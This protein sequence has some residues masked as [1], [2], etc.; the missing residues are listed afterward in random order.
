MKIYFLLLIEVIFSFIS[1]TN[2]EDLINQVYIS[3]EDQTNYNLNQIYI[4]KLNS[5]HFSC[6][7]NKK[8]L[9]LDKFNDNY[10]DCEDGSDENQ[11]NACVNGKF[12]CH[13]HLY[14]SKII[15]TSKIG[16]G[17][18][19]CC[20]G[21]DEPNLNCLNECL[22]LSNLEYKKYLS[23][24][25]ILSSILD[26]YSE[27]STTGYFNDT[28]IYI[29]EINKTYN[30]IKNLYQ[31]KILIERYLNSKTIQKDESVISQGDLDKIL[32]II[33]NKINKLK[34]ELIEEEDNI[35][36]LIKM[37]TFS[38]ILGQNKLKLNF[39]D[40]SCELTKNR[41]YCRDESRH[42][43]SATRI[44][45]LNFGQL[46]HIENNVAI[47]NKG[48]DCKGYP[49][50]SMTAEI[51]F[52]CG[53]KDEFKLNYIDNLCFY[54]FY[55]YTYLACNNAQINNILQKIDLIINH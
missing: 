37:G 14:F 45:R 4:N 1:K 25:N 10:C 8:I 34:N 35:Y 48:Y 18:C 23:D 17:I 46:S 24:F 5:T 44:E 3:N 41:F 30:T 55:Y 31:D 28:F 50:V 39:D 11:T 20:D 12:Y 29:S 22:Y 2:N 47:F 52:L 9:S 15:S 54:S 51:I 49:G 32:T 43:K 27:E 16:D 7:N 26:S 6:D 13:N 36:S 42:S 38:E 19:D 33:N 40:Y 21:A 53:K